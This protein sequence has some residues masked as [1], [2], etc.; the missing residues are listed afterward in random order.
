[1]LNILALETATDACSVAIMSGDAVFEVH[2]VAARQ[3]TDL[4][5]AMIERV[6][7]EAGLARSAVDLIAFGRGPGTFTG[8]RIAAGVAQGIALAN[9]VPLAP[10]STLAALAAGG[11]RLYG[12][13][14]ILAALDARRAQI[15]LAALRFDDSYT[16]GESVIADCVLAPEAV[17]LAAPTQWLAVG[18]AWPSYHA[19]FAA[20]IAAIPRRDL[21]Y[22]HAQDVARLGGALHACG[23]SVAVADALPMYL[24]GAVD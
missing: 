6:L 18:N 22:P 23:G 17:V 9:G 20:D 15:Y 7:A 12:G 10:V 4:L 13:R 19:R 21:L 1:M 24:R 3:H 5:F 11:A 2:E 16:I 14:Q 8:V